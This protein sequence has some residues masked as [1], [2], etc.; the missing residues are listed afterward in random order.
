MIK[1]IDAVMLR[2]NIGSHPSLESYKVQKWS[3]LPATNSATTHTKQ[4]ESGGL[5]DSQIVGEN[6]VAVA[7]RSEQ[8]RADFIG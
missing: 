7:A 4:P 8:I 1:V 6:A 2:M 5:G 3:T